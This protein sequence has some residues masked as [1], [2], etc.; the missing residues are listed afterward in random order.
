MTRPLISILGAYGV[1]GRSAARLL[2]RWGVGRLRLGGRHVEL[3]RRLADE[4][5]GGEADAQEVDAYQS[6]QVRDFCAGCRVVVNC[7]GPSFRILDRV[8]VAAFGAG[9]DY[10]DP[11][12][13]APVYGRLIADEWTRAGRTALLTA[14]MMPGL[15]GLLPR[16][17]AGQGF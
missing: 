15:S 12:G 10:V 3:A 6:E 7:A 5:L 2:H 9:A 13:D 1:V 11:G 4:D 14:G 16:W 8:A 17:L